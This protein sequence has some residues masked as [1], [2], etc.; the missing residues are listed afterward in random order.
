MNIR[1]SQAFTLVEI[2]VVIV[3]LTII[4]S[5]GAGTFVNTRKARELETMTDAI[6]AKLEQAK[7]EA[8]SGKGGS[9]FGVKFTSSSYTYFKGGSYSSSGATNMTYPLTDGYQITASIPASS[10]TA[11]IFARM[12]GTPVATGTVSISNSASGSKVNIIRIG[13]LGDITVIK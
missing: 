9:A 10:D 2:I 7:S 12:T 11:I 5:I 4:F 8:I 13:N 6:A 3:I 1:H